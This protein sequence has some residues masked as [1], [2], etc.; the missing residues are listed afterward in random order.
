MLLRRSLAA[1]AV[2]VIMLATSG[3]A[4]M[5]QSA[6]G[7]FMQPD[8]LHGIIRQ[9][10]Y[11]RDPFAR[12]PAARG[13]NTYNLPNIPAEVKAAL[14]GDYPKPQAPWVAP[15]LAQ[16]DSM[17]ANLITGMGTES[18]YAYAHN[19]PLTYRDPSGLAADSVSV[20]M[21][22]ALFLMSAAAIAVNTATQA[23]ARPNIGDL[24]DLRE[25]VKT[26]GGIIASTL[27]QCLRDSVP[28]DD[29]DTRTAKGTWCYFTSRDVAPIRPVDAGWN[30][31]MYTCINVDTGQVTTADVLTPVGQPCF[32]EDGESFEVTQLPRFRPPR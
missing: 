1:L 29:R 15:T 11:N 31:C 17:Q 13:W 9:N 10:A 21:V 25:W 6:A 20:T 14:R 19:N 18:A 28:R 23:G 24:N 27:T 7:R 30:V 16:I 12:L 5:A 26:L 3:Q 22:K 32:K 4:A 2:A 8:P